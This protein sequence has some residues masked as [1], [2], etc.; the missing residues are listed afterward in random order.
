M[1]EKISVFFFISYLIICLH[2][3]YIRFKVNLCTVQL[4]FCIMSQ[5]EAKH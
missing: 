3:F 5:C 1:D 2:T 4:N